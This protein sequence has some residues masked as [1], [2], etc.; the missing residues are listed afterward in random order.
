[1]PSPQGWVYGVFWEEAPPDA[2]LHAI[3]S[4]KESLTIGMIATP[5]VPQRL[6]KV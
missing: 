5:L 1:M 6:I 3:Q 4:C 2:N